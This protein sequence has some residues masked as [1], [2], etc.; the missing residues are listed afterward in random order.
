M[1][2]ILQ[3]YQ[4]RCWFTQ[5]IGKIWVR[6]NWG[7]VL[8]AL[9]TTGGWFQIQKQLI[10]WGIGSHYSLPTQNNQQALLNGGGGGHWAQHWCKSPRAQ[11]EIFSL[12]FQI[13]WKLIIWSKKHIESSMGLLNAI[14][15]NK[16][17]W[18]FNQSLDAKIWSKAHGIFMSPF[19][20]I[21]WSK[22]WT[23]WIFPALWMS[24]IWNK[25]HSTLMRL[26]NAIIIM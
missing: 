1:S 3:W 23:H 4:C 18:I 13:V 7:Q 21:I 6:R 10:L 26:F 14:I 19:N 9:S 17:H 15:W 16:T 22:N 12:V 8:L 2:F 11:Q 20:A 25:T 5:D 24:I